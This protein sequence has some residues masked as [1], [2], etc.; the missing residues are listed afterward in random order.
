MPPLSSDL[1]KSLDKAVVAARDGAE[2]ACERP[3]APGRAGRSGAARHHR[4]AA[5]PAQRPARQAAPARR[6][7]RAAGQR[8]RLRAV[9]PDAVRP[10]PRRERPAASTRSGAPVIA[11]R[12]RRAGRARR[13]SATPGCSPPATPRRCCPAS[14]KPTTPRAGSPFAPEGRKA[15]EDILERLPAE[16][17][18]ADDALGWVYQFW[19][20]EAEG[21]GQ[22]VR[23]TRSA[24]PTSPR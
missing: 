6:R 10:L 23:A 4:R 18:T 2:S 8:V 22:R 5:R 7:L 19:Q 3:C 17:F 13:A 16:V 1:R 9:A 12:G 24:A 20:S 21:R 11:R 15:L 14:S